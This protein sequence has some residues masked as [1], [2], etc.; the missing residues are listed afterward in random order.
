MYQYQNPQVSSLDIILIDDCHVCI[1]YS[2]ASLL[3]SF[4]P[5]SYSRLMGAYD[6]VADV[7]LC[8]LA[9][10][11]SPFSPTS[12]PAPHILRYD[13]LGLWA[14]AS[15]PSHCSLSSIC[16]SLSSSTSTRLFSHIQ[17]YHFANIPL[18]TCNVYKSYHTE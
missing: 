9:S 5:S 18:R 7:R 13:T 14:M 15:V 8:G 1:T 2:F 3:L 12:F 16:S 17:G 10:F 4:I 6:Y 11:F